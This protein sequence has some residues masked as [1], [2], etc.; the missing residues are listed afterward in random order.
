MTTPNPPS[1][2]LIG[3][4]AVAIASADFILAAVGLPTYS[5]I[6]G[7]CVQH[8]GPLPEGVASLDAKRADREQAKRLEARL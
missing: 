7:R 2:A 5:A 8:V 6:I 3:P 4:Q 1:A